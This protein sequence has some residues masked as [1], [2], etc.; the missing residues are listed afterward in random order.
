M[1]KVGDGG[2]ELTEQ[3]RATV[4]AG[5]ARWGGIRSVEERK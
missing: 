3:R 4:T 2:M 1:A 5:G